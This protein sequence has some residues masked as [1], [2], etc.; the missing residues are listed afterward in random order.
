[1]RF[2]V[3]RAVAILFAVAA[4][5]SLAAADEKEQLFPAPIDL[6]IPKISDDSSIKYDYDIAYV[7]APRHGDTAQSRWADI[8]NPWVMDAGADLMLLHPDGSEEILVEG[9]KGSIT[10]PVVTFD[11]K[12]I[13]YSH[14]HDLSKDT[15]YE[16]GAGADIYR[17]DLASRKIARLT[18]QTF[19]PNLGAAKAWTSDYHTPGKPG[20][21][22]LAYGVY[23]MGPCPLPGGRLMFVSNRNAFRSPKHHGGAM[24]LF[25]MDEDGANL[26]CIGHMNIGM[27]LHPNVLMDG[28]V[29]FSTMESQGLRNSILWGLWSIHPD[30]TYWQQMIS[31]FDTG[32]APNAFHFQ[33]QLSDG[34]IIAEEYYNQNNSGFGA[35]FK[36][37][38]PANSEPSRYSYQFGATYAPVPDPAFG[39]AFTDDSRNPL[40][41]FGRFENSRPKTYR[42]PFSPLES[43]SFTRFANNGEGPADPSLRENKNS[44]AVGKFTHPAA[45]PD[46]HL[47]TVWSPGPI[48]HQNFVHLPTADGGI[49]LI[50]SGDPIDE[51][52]QMRLIKNDPNYNEQWPRAVVPYK[53]I[54]GQNEPSTVAEVEN[55]GSQSRLLPPGSPFGLVGASSLYKRESYPNGAVPAG[56][57]T[58]DFAGQH[59]ANGYQGLDPFNTSENG[60]SLNW[61]NQGSEAGRYSNDDIHAI[62]ILVMEPTT[63]RHRGNYPRD[64]RLFYSHA[65]ERLR[66]LGEIPVRKIGDDGNQPL[67]PDGN[68]D[69][70]FL[71]KIPADTAF[72]FQ[73]L[74]KEG[75]VLN[76]A[77]TWHQVRPGE[78]RT[79][80]GGCHAHSQKPTLFDQTAASR[81]DYELFDLTKHTP[82]LTAKAGD[83]SNW[84]WDTDRQAGLRYESRVKNVEYH[85]DI[86]PIFARSCAACHTREAKNPP[87]LLVLDDTAVM[88][89]PEDN[90]HVP[91][92]YYRL[93][94]DTRAKFGYK[95]V[96]HNGEW[97]NQN[98]SRYIR[99]F[100]SRRSLL[101]WKI[102]GHRTDG[103]T[104]DDFPSE[105]IPGDPNSLKLKGE[106]VANTQ[107]N[108]DRA[109]LDYN[110]HQMPPPEAVA[111]AYQSPDGKKIKVEPLS[112]EDRRTIIR[113]IDLGCPIDLDYDPAHPDQCGYGWMCDDNRPVL[114]VTSPERGSNPELNRILIGMYDYDS[115]LDMDSFT[116]MADFA[117]DGASPGENLA[118][119]F[120]N[121]SAGIWDW[122]PSKPVSDL[123]KGKLAVSV[124]DRQGNIS[125]IERTISVDANPPH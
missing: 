32:S 74:D 39:P 62:R 79:D 76:M 30:G 41:R 43:E 66:I 27:A 60:A 70:S 17:I 23:N 31:A 104:N 105:T 7:R 90:L 73:T 4:P 98:A 47:L 100:Q 48:N 87:G 75:M 19:T 80:C 125:L 92:T 21:T 45:A 42:L 40:F 97:R 103:W 36:L 1:M 16:L 83:S 101:V 20:E 10:D 38:P 46:N 54:Y 124:K 64:G 109:D 72:T 106:P 95:P 110:G 107:Q 59:D 111:G 113:W 55:N 6:K 67:D 112:D 117:I 93:A 96:I 33:A 84:R 14:I 78:I 123:A 58:A 65:Q 25:V 13:F 50:K 94:L 2:Q 22:Y 91:G 77:Q 86:E 57:V 8:S 120:K 12:S 69:T 116:V 15:P 29:M 108:R 37:R 68:P 53:R 71:A 81:S 18:G 61:F 63:D 44:P 85:R 34:S 24:Q 122:R 102:M 88:Q 119:R 28:R 52:A 3:F 26:D 82:L 115:G 118:K 99:K 9:G 35:Y 11:G 5:I 114:T 121:T 51:P 89:T 56:K 49:Y